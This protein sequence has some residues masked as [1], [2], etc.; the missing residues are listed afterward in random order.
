M[1][2]LYCLWRNAQFFISA[3]R[4]PLCYLLG[5]LSCSV[6]F[7]R[8]GCILAIKAMKF[9]LFL[10]IP[11][12]RIET[13]TA[14]VLAVCVHELEPLMLRRYQILHDLVSLPILLKQVLDDEI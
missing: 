7:I 2:K 6:L 4:I 9:G 11:V 3:F 10:I 8:L 1:S 14:A 13:T 5:F 12:E